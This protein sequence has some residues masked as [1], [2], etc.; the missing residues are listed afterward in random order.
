MNDAGLITIAAFA[1]PH[2]DVRHRVKQL[3]G[4]NPVVHVHVDTPIET[5]RRW[6]TS[7]RYLAGERGENS[8]TSPT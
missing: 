3:L 5:C 8:R 4:S 7:G 2:E 1:A 6:D